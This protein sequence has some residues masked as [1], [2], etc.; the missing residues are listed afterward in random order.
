MI[1]VVV[2]TFKRSV[3]LEKC[4]KSIEN[5]FV[6]EILLFND[7]ENTELKSSQL[8]ISNTL[9]NIIKIY[10]PTDFGFSD[11][12]FRKPIYINKSVKLASNNHILFSDDDGIFS[13]KSIE[14]HAKALAIYPFC[15]G[16]I[17]RNKLIKRKS[18]TILQ[19]TN[20]SFKKDFFNDIGGYDES[21]VQSNGGGDVD[22][23]YRIYNY[24]KKNNLEAVYLPNASQNVISKSCRKRDTTKMD[25]QQYTLK[26][27]ALDCRGPMY[28][29]FP[30]IR[31]KNKWM[32]IV[33]EF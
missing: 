4:L 22:F 16:S 32:K 8:N 13:S 10:N 19:G 17:I 15:A 26:K 28:K 33:E 12:L 25:P 20:Y 31:N 3:L 18:K 23:W 9:K 7:D 14:L 6:N 5:E 30:E 27:H 24:I 21:F 2:F 1:T 29:W 11:R